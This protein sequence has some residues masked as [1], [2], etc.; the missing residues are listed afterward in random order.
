MRILT[1][2]ALAA[3]LAAC[4]QA[5]ATSAQQPMANAARACYCGGGGN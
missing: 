1:V 5:P 2:V 3:L 4:G